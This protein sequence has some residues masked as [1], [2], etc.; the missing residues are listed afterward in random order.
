[1]QKAKGAVQRNTGM[2]TRSSRGSVRAGVDDKDEGITV[3]D[4]VHHPSE[5]NTGTHK[6][7]PKP[8]SVTPHVM[9]RRASSPQNLPRTRHNTDSKLASD[10]SVPKETASGPGNSGEA[11]TVVPSPRSADRGGIAQ[12]FATKPAVAR[13]TRTKN[14]S[15]RKTTPSADTSKKLSKT[16]RK[17]TTEKFEKR[18][19]DT[20]QPVMH[21]SGDAARPLTGSDTVDGVIRKLD[22]SVESDDDEP[23]DKLKAK[24]DGAIGD[25]AHDRDDTVADV[26]DICEDAAHGRE[27][28]ADVCG[29][30]NVLPA[31][32]DDASEARE[33]ENVVNTV[34]P[35]RSAHDA[36]DV[37]CV[38]VP[39]D[40][41]RVPD[42]DEDGAQPD[43]GDVK[44]HDVLRPDR[45]PIQPGS[46]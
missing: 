6:A 35:P 27:D 1:M 18:M 15:G 17:V 39:Y 22:L 30:D 45:V 24:L 36:N 31:R 38:D 5:R 19:V 7:G 3:G 26:V 14:G 28:T 41:R 21:D 46:V 44:S 10:G 13:S 11:S 37:D 4:D 23:L 2:R 8:R 32:C 33:E 16:S 9:K 34:L 20:V 40:E 12:Y 29:D 43:A 42:D 25:V